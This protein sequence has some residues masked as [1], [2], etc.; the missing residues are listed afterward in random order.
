MLARITAFVYGLV[1]YLVFFG[2]FLYAIGFIG[3]LV[4]PRS[5][6]SG[7]EAELAP[8]LLINAGLLGL[9]AV[10]H[11]LMARE[12]F[13][14]AWTRVI[15]EPAERSTYVLF[16][17]LLLLLLFWQWRP[18]GMMIWNVENPMGR[19]G[20]RALYAMGWLTVLGSTFLINHFDLFGLRQVYFNLVG[21]PYSPLG[22]RTPGPYRY[23]RHPLYFGW[24]LVFWSA[25][26]MT[27]AHLVFALATTAYILVAIQFE[28]RDLIRFYGDAYRRYRKQVPMIMPLRL[29]KDKSPA[30]TVDVRA[31]LM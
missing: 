1:C 31:K 30:K 13:K 16:S 27:A 4:V 23:V 12:W 26:T 10:Q 22:F 2:T 29:G 5:I 18:M 9:F 17:S 25:P 19:I 24:L 15:P 20:L 8:A 11:S 7:P 3:N 14:R 6:D 28:E 21:R